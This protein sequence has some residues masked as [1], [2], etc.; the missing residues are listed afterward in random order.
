MLN[1]SHKINFMSI[2]FLC[3]ANISVSDCWLTTNEQFYSYIGIMTRTSYI[4]WDDDVCF[5]L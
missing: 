3:V 4:Q 5:V 2:L 1:K